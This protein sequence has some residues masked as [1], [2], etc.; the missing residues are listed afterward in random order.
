MLQNSVKII[1]SGNWTRFNGYYQRET[2]L[3]VQGNAYEFY[4]SLAK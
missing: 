3:F 2:A 4:N 1:N